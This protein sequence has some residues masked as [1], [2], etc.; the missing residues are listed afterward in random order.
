MAIATL[1][2][3]LVTTQTSYWALSV[4]GDVLR[5]IRTMLDA[6]TPFGIVTSVEINKNE[7]KTDA[8]LSDLHVTMSA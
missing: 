8:L 1:T 3:T 5:A 2:G 6:E 4:N 7:R